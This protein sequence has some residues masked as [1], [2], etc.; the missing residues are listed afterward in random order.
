MR[1]AM[2]RGAMLVLGWAALAAPAAAQLDSVSVSPDVTLDLAATTFQDEDVPVDNLAGVVVG[3]SLGSLPANADLAAYH[4]LGNGDQL[5]ALDTAVTL[6]GPL[7]AEPRDVVRYD[8]LA[9]TLEFDG[10]AEGVPDGAGADAVSRSAAGDLLL[11]FDGAVDLGAVVAHD[12]DLVAF[13]GVDFSLVFD[14]SVEGVPDGLDL[15]GAHDLEDGTFALSFD[16]SGR[17]GGVDFDDEDVLLFDPGGP[18]WALAYD[19]SA[20]HATWSPADV[21]AVAVPEPGSWPA[22]ATGLAA[23]VLLRCRSSQSPTAGRRLCASRRAP[24]D[25]DRRPAQDPPRAARDRR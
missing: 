6:P 15:D 2:A 1:N 25:R 8:G 23:L 20:E 12:E 3:A 10:G 16:G 18:T 7:V 22:L 21:D 17:L 19:G 9:Y 24:A 5:F 4:L 13:D 11:S 14:G